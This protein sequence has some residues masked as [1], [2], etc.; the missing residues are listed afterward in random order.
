MFKELF[1]IVERAPLMLLITR[2]G[3][4]L[5]VATTQ[6]KGEKDDFVPLNLSILAT[7]D[8]LDRELPFAIA[9]GA[10][11]LS[12]ETAKSVGDQVKGQVENAKTADAPVDK[13]KSTRKAPAAPKAAK[14]RVKRDKPKKAAKPAPPARP[15]KPAKKRKSKAAAASAEAVTPSATTAVVPLI[16]PLLSAEELERVNAQT[17][18]PET[19]ETAAPEVPAATTSTTAASEVAPAST[20]STPAVATERAADD[21]DS[22]DLFR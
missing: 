15:P 19:A 7:P 14:V 3:D 20:P 10:A 13:K 2:E 22:I 17:P 21:D 8:E 1:P 5:R 4:K 6:K 12:A 11:M 18:A 16:R 9:E